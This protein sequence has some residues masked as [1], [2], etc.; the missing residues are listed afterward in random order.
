S[1]SA[2][3]GAVISAELA[4]TVAEVKFENGAVAKKGDV[5]V[6]LDTSSEDAQLHTAEADLELARA[7]LQRARDLATRR[8]ISKS[9]LDSAE[10]KFKQKQGTVDNMRAMIAK[11]EVRAPFDG[12]FGIRQSIV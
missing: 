5:L 9:E 7:D 1:L 8:V 2:V 10:S 4:G 11:K 3:Q 12:S 6:K